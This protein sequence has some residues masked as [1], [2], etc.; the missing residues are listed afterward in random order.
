MKQKRIFQLSHIS[1]PCLVRMLTRHCWMIVAMALIAGLT[2]SLALTWLHVPTYQATMT[3][4][5]TSRSNSVLSTGNMTSTKE[6][7]AVLT[8]LLTTDVMSNGIREHDPRL[9]GFSGTISASQVPDSNFIVVTAT[10]GTPEQA[11]LALKALI[12]VFPEMAD[13]ISNRN[14]LTLMRNP[15]V[16]AYPSNQMDIPGMARMGGLAGAVLMAGLLCFM[17]VMSD[18]IQTRTGAREQLDAPILA[19][20]CHERKNRT[21][22]TLFKR[23]NRQVHV[24]APTTSFAYAEQISAVCTHLENEAAARGKKVFLITGVGESEGKSTVSANVA[25][26]MALKGH[27][28]ALVDCDL[29][30]P[31]MNSFFDKVYTSPL[32]LNRMLALPYSAERVRQCMVLNEELGLYMLFPVNGDL[33]STELLSGSTL[34]PLLQQLRVF[35]FVIVD[36]PP[37]GM[38]PDAEIIAEV[39]DAS[40]LVVRQDYTAACDVNDAIDTLNGCGSEFLGVIL[41]DML[42]SKTSRYGYGA[43]GYGYGDSNK[44]KY[45]SKYAYSSQSS[46]SNG[47]SYDRP[48][49]KL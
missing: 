42:T 32:P 30:K 20:I 13:F 47:S 48:A 10:A 2:V 34:E 29:R 43:Y 16:S 27:K 14:I 15:T 4:A 33:R 41:N 23:S 40:M 24:Y 6:V 9:A 11:F 26:S 25:A 46:S 44:Y 37:M 3:Y 12:Q 28:V 35:D 5:V 21:L 8:E 36:S 49:N 18:T 45:G 31:A 38:F 17:S 22:K 7:T 1:I 39:V 19:T